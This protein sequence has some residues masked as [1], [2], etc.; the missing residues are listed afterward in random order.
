KVTVPLGTSAMARPRSVA[1][2]LLAGNGSRSRVAPQCGLH[3]I[4]A[5][6]T[7]A[8]VGDGQHA[9]R[10]CSSILYKDAKSLCIT[11]TSSAAEAR[12]SSP[13]H[14]STRRRERRAHRMQRK[15]RHILCKLLVL[16]AACPIQHRPASQRK[17]L[18]AN[19]LAAS[20]RP[21]L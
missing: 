7:H 17:G 5:S 15:P 6:I 10:C 16:Q 9:G 8:L 21:R 12:S 2:H 4:G 20:C 18:V 13:D 19:L 1:V 14:G 3:E 11:A